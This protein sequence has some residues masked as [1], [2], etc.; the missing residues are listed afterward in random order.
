MQITKVDLKLILKGLLSSSS[1]LSS[2]STPFHFRLFSA[3]FC[4]I[5]PCNVRQK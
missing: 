3:I 5:I 2:W 4:G 1:S